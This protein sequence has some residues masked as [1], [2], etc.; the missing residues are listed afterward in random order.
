M[1]VGAPHTT[2]PTTEN[3]VDVGHLL[4]EIWGF[5]WNSGYLAGVPDSV[6]IY[7]THHHDTHLALVNTI[8]HLHNSVTTNLTLDNWND[9]S[10]H[11]FQDRWKEHKSGHE[12]LASGLKD[13]SKG[14]FDFADQMTYFNDNIHW[15]LVSIAA[16]YGI[17]AVSAWIPGVNIFTTAANAINISIQV[18]RFWSLANLWKGILI[19][20][21][22]ILQ[23]VGTNLP[24]I[25][26]NIGLEYRKQMWVNWGLRMGERMVMFGGDFTKG[27]NQYDAA[28]I[29]FASWQNVFLQAF[30]IGPVK[31]GAPY[32]PLGEWSRLIPGDWWSYARSVTTRFIQVGGTATLYNFVNH[33][34]IQGQ[35]F[36]FNIPQTLWAGTGFSMITTTIMVI[37]SFVILR[38]RSTV[39][40]LP[41]EV[42]IPTVLFLNGIADVAIPGISPIV[43]EARGL[44]Y[45]SADTKLTPAQ[46]KVVQDTTGIHG[47][48]PT[49][50]VQPGQTI[51]QIAMQQYGEVNPKIIADI[52]KANGGITAIHEGEVLVMPSIPA[53]DL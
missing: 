36:K 46:L 49:L 9:D 11:A 10:G 44:I 23:F 37:G 8:T 16:S 20:V 35:G 47:Q 41:Q 30:L 25:V 6:R 7:A 51:E 13:Q 42:T 52:L 53:S 14:L 50:T 28:Q 4:G 21:K 17:E 27:W 24:M 48:L 22:T 3:T 34:L 45:V 2:Q 1:V 15:T 12:A 5:L 39:T 26:R 31:S 19:G 38:G 40:G 18:D 32:G 33:I 29:Q 43:R